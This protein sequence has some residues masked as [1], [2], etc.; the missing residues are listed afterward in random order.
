MRDRVRLAIEAWLPWYDEHLEEGRSVRSE[1][2]HRR[3]I[4][5]RIL[6]ERLTPA[7]LER[8]ASAYAAYARA[9]TRR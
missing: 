2:I 5:A 7:E 6:A 1:D 4:N 3:S 8:L 9:L